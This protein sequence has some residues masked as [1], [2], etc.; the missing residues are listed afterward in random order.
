MRKSSV[1]LPALLIGVGSVVLLHNFGVLQLDL[2]DL[3][4]HTWPLLLII[5]GI[6]MILWGRSPAA[7]VVAALLI[8]GVIVAGVYGYTNRQ[9]R[10][11][12][13]P[14]Y[15]LEQPLADARR[16]SVAAH[17]GVGTLDIQAA[18]NRRVLI[19]G[20]LRD[21]P[22]ERIS[23]V[24]RESDGHASY[25][26]RAEG[27]WFYLPPF[28]GD[29]PYWDLQ[30]SPT[31]PLSLDLNLGTGSSRL[32]LGDLRLTDLRS[33]VGVGRTTITLPREGS[34]QGKVIGGVGLV[35]LLLLE[36]V[37]LELDVGSGLVARRMPEGF[38][39]E[40]ERYLSPGFE[41]AEHQI[42]LELELGLG[43]LVVEQTH[44]R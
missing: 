9:E 44:E 28:T 37:G 20:A 4:L 8:G 24:L 1:V 34:F 36:G 31:I 26:L 21:E 3:A 6:D 18:E 39:R 38:I 13:G 23:E 16:G 17:A 22:S 2:W 25:V 43:A 12:G 19:M 15:E 5:T 30:L 7:S 32:D 14:A 29:P 27:F 11:A 10:R 41:R 42:R 40:G 35:R 33:W